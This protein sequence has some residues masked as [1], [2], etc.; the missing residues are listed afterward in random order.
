[1]QEPEEQPKSQVYSYHPEDFLPALNPVESRANC[2]QRI[3][4]DRYSTLTPEKSL[5]PVAN[6][7]QNADS[8]CSNVDIELTPHWINID[9]TSL[10]I[11]ESWFT[12]SPTESETPSYLGVL[13][14]LVYDGA[15]L[16]RRRAD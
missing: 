6:Q 15:D 2:G 4:L 1:M 16:S 8:D 13:S 5:S 14:E 3:V 7:V 11:D 12:P 10:D 9:L